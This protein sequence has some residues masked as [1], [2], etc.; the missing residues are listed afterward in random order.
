MVAVINQV[1]TGIDLAIFH[2]RVS[3][4]AD[5][6]LTRIVPDKV[7]DHARQL[8]FAFDSRRSVRPLESH[9]NHRMFP[10]APS[11]ARARSAPGD[12]LETVAG[13]GQS[14]RAVLA[15]VARLHKNRLARSQL[16]R[17]I[18]RSSPKFHA[19]GLRPARL[20]AE[21]QSAVLVSEARDDCRFPRR[22]GREGRR[23]LRRG[24][25]RPRLSPCT[26]RNPGQKEDADENRGEGEA[27][28]G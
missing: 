23:G 4:Y 2:S 17:Q 12:L 3:R 18:P 24:A 1:D 14:S 10:S 15:A 25:V 19:L 26:P 21:R 16:D 27:E 6:P 9:P 13:E 22:A 28:P 8:V 20:K 11:R 7:V 5:A